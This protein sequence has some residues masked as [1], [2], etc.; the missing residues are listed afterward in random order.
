MTPPGRPGPGGSG[1]A[2]ADL[3]PAVGVDIGGTKVAGGL[4]GADGVVLDT[5]GRATPGASV[6][7]TEDAIVAVV[8]E[9][10]ARSTGA[11]A[12]VGV[13]A[14]GARSASCTRSRTSTSCMAPVVGCLSIFRRSAQ[15]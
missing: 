11:V 1:A 2:G 10:V 7:G 5:A 12:G 9:L 6:T 4:V 14:A 13:G 15:A 8:T 3:P